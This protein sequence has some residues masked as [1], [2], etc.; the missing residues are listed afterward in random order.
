MSNLAITFEK[1]PS[2]KLDFT[3]DWSN[4][5]NDVADSI[6]SSAWTV[7]GGIT[8]VTDTNTSTAATI[9]LQGGTDGDSYTLINQ[10]TTANSPPRIYRQPIIV[11]V[12]T[13]S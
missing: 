3:I 10:I 4:E 5:L 9:W 8:E 6:A 12:K 11:S 13:K 7:P 1:D 2:E